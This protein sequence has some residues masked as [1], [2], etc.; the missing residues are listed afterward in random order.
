M[1]RNR[2]SV[3]KSLFAE[4]GDVSNVEYK[5][6]SFKSTTTSPL[7]SGHKQHNAIKIGILL[8]VIAIVSLSK[9]GNIHLVTCSHSH[10]YTTTTAYD[11]I[12]PCTYRFVVVH[13]SESCVYGVASYTRARTYCVTTHQQSNAI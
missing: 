5:D 2:D 4:Y 10:T 3:R 6:D 12:S 1:F 9:Y 8:I 11:P 13:R 7:L